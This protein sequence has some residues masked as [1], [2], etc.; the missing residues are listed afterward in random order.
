MLT[1]NHVRPLVPRL[2]PKKNTPPTTIARKR[3]RFTHD[4]IPPRLSSF[5]LRPMTAQKYSLVDAS[6]VSVSWEKSALPTCS[7]TVLLSAFVNST[8]STSFLLSLT[9][10]LVPCGRPLKPP[11]A[12]TLTLFRL[13]H[14][15]GP[16]H[17]SPCSLPN[18]TNEPVRVMA[19]RKR[20]M[21]S[22]PFLIVASG[23]LAY[24]SCSVRKEEM[25][26]TSAERPTKEWN[27]A[28]I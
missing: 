17:P 7:V 1:I 26:V 22:A 27:S 11:P 23:M 24:W 13:P 19:P 15:L 10:P 8:V 20:P 6:D 12:L 25:L 21:Y 28:T 14:L 3:I 5:S 2:G 18:A 4:F 16:N 9:C